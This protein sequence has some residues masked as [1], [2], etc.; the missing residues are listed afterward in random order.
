MKK[1]SVKVIFGKAACN[2]Y[3]ETNGDLWAVKSYIEKDC[4][5]IK[6]VSFDTKEECLAYCQ[7]LADSFGWENYTIVDQLHF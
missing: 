7:G 1:H 6:D 3:D 5:E 4:G 2:V